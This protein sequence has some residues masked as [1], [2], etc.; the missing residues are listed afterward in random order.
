MSG[1][2]Q[3]LILTSS[4]AL[5]GGC[6]GGGGG[7]GESSGGGSGSATQIAVS[8]PSSSGAGIAFTITVTAVDGANNTAAD[9]SGMVHFTSSDPAAALPPDSTLVMALEPSPPH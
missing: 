7:G 5:V 3:V 4:L 1:F 6:G 8:G 9:Y 2:S